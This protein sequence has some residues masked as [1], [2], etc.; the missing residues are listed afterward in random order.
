L[1]RGGTEQS[2]AK[3]ATLRASAEREGR[4]VGVCLERP[5]TAILHRAD[6]DATG[7][8]LPPNPRWS[9]AAEVM[10]PE[11][12][13]E[14]IAACDLTADERAEGTESRPLR[15]AAGDGQYFP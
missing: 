9:Q 11:Q 15:A 14:A 4:Q 3:T 10:S 13:M 1:I 5:T 6:F 7:Q 8:P 2:Y 12:V